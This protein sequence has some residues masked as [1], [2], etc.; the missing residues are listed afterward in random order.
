MFTVFLPNYKHFSKDLRQN[1]TYQYTH[2]G[3]IV[4]D[5]HTLISIESNI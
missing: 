3:F 2:S 4:T 5:T 1:M